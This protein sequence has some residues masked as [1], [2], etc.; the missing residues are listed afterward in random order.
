VNIPANITLP[1]LNHHLFCENTLKA[2]AQTLHSPTYIMSVCPAPVPY[3]VGLR[4]IMELITE[5]QVTKVTARIV[6]AYHITDTIKESARNPRQT[7]S[8]QVY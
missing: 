8:S 3:I 6:G 5:M 7:A 4:K 2:Y 1:L